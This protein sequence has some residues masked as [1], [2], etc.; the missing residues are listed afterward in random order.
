[1]LVAVPGNFGPNKTS[2][3]LT[4]RRPT[5]LTAG[6]LLKRESER[7]PSASFGMA[8]ALLLP[9]PACLLAC[10]VLLTECY[11]VVFYVVAL[12]TNERSQAIHQQRARQP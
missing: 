2:F 3:L 4:R 12:A 9:G 11:L 5:V 7:T 6:V 8:R 1:M 10:L